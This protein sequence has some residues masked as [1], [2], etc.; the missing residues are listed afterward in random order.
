MVMPALA[1]AYS[2]RRRRRC[3][4]RCGTWR[5]AAVA[6]VVSAGWFV[7]LTMLWPASSRPYLAGSTDNNFMNLVLGYNGF[8]RVLGRT[9]WGSVRR[10][11]W[12]ERR[13]AR[14][15]MSPG[16]AGSAASAANRRAGR[17]CSPAS[18]ASRSAGWCPRRW[19]RPCWS[20]CPAGARRAQTWYARGGDAVRR[21]APG[22]RAGAELHARHRSTPYYSLSIAPPVAAMFAIGVQQTVAAPRKVVV[23]GR[24]GRTDLA[25]GRVGLVAARRATATGCLRLRWTILVLAVAAAVA[26]LGRGAGAPRVALGAARRRTGR[27]ACA[28]P[29]RTR[30]RRSARRIRAAARRSGPPTATEQRDCGFG[31]NVGQPRTRRHAEG[32]EHPVVGRDRRSSRRGPRIVHGHS[33]DGDRWLLGHRPGADAAQFQDDVAQHGR[34]LR[35]HEHPRAT[36]RAGAIGATPTSRSG[37]RP[38]PLDR[39]SATSRCTT[40]R[41]R[42]RC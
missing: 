15:C 10:R 38:L 26:L 12:S 8:A 33:G 25:D 30:S 40:C 5:V 19:S 18:S 24:S 37:S 9:T 42:S 39:R 1:A 11:T 17:G 22:R 35:R 28:V 23:P 13:R 20:W 29:R 3:G 4:P 36:A 32:H 6:F 41:R 27:R 21:L 34:L 14:S 2:S 16:T 31:Q 7:V